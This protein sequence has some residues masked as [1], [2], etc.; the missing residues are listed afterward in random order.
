MELKDQVVSLELAKRLKELGVKQ[1]SL[2][3]WSWFDY[4]PKDKYE[5]VNREDVNTDYPFYSAFTTSELGEML[6]EAIR[7]GHMTPEGYDGILYILSFS[8]SDDRHFLTY[9]SGN[10]WKLAQFDADTEADGR[11]KCLIYL[12]ENGLVKTDEIQ[13][14]THESSERMGKSK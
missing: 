3:W 10:G 1:E 6:P 9:K 4:A 2:F 5:L 13:R 12:I 8:R 7:E 14:S 11:A